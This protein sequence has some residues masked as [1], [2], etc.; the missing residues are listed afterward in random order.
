MRNS[1]RGGSNHLL[2]YASRISCRKYICSGYLCQD[3]LSKG[4][5]CLRIFLE[6]CRVLLSLF[7][8][9]SGAFVNPPRRRFSVHIWCGES[10]KLRLP[11]WGAIP[12]LATGYAPTGVYLAELIVA[13][14]NKPLTRVIATGR[15]TR[16]ALSAAAPRTRV[17]STQ[18]A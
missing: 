16:R 12:D 5:I 2:L 14:V 6:S 17:H 13:S 8:L 1:C 15:C 9:S 7:F 3:H 18:T 10:I 4:C 11:L